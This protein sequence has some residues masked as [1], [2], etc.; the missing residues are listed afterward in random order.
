[1]CP[2]TGSANCTTIFQGRTVFTNVTGSLTY[3][4]RG[5]STG[6]AAFLTERV[7]LADQV[8][9]I[10][11]LRLDRYIAELDS[12]TYAGAA[13]P[14]GGLKVKSNLVSPRV[15][16]LWEPAADRTFYFTWGRSQTPQGTSIVGAGAALTV[17]AEDLEPEDTE[18]WELG[19]K[20]GVPGPRL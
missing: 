6:L 5:V 20:V 10:G 7:W 9:V 13:S 15:S 19:A 14:P 2:T 3:K 1:V 8:S 4:S 12:V 18:M 16:L 11:S 17:S